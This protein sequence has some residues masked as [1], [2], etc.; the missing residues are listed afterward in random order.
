MVYVNKVKEKRYYQTQGSYLTQIP[1]PYVSLLVDLKL[2][3]DLRIQVDIHSS[4]TFP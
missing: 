1:L 3:L 2:H 4:P